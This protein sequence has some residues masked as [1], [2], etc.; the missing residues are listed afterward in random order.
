MSQG[1][2]EYRFQISILISSSNFP[3]IPMIWRMENP[4]EES[5]QTLQ[6]SLI[7]RIGHACIRVNYQFNPLIG[8]LVH[9]CLCTGLEREKVSE[10]L[11]KE[12]KTELREYSLLYRTYFCGFSLQS[13]VMNACCVAS[14]IL[15]K[16]KCEAGNTLKTRVPGTETD[17]HEPDGCQV[18]AVYVRKNSTYMFDMAKTALLSTFSAED[19]TWFGIQ[20]P[21]GSSPPGPTPVP[22]Q[23]SSMSEIICIWRPLFCT[24]ETSISIRTSITAAKQERQPG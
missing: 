14:K 13:N 4:F 21:L 23:T 11:R 20:A 17:K 22:K 16:M 18:A 2:M 10:L 3:L 24:L 1:N 5:R 19:S 6:D 7:P 9:C 12:W 15:W 8:H